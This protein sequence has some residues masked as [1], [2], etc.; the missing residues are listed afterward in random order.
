MIGGVQ[1]RKL[2]RY[3]AK[4][5][6]HAGACIDDIYDY[7]A[8]LLKKKPSTVMLHVC[9]NDAK[10]KSSDQIIAELENLKRYIERS[11]PNVLVVISCP[12]IRTDDKKANDVL[13]EVDG[14][15]KSLFVNFIDNDN[16]DKTYLS[17]KGLHL[18]QKGTG[19]LARN[20]IALLQRL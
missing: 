15:I 9:T 1:E 7:I 14:K 19:R 6:C 13:R 2:S 5:R 4:V 3:F 18:N 12:V 11:I 10:R 17:K 16:I 8:P 20:F